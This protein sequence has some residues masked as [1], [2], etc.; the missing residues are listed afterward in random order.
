MI[1]R[2]LAFILPIVLCVLP[3]AP[4]RADEDR[5]GRFGSP[6]PTPVDRFGLSVAFAGD[7][8]LAGSHLD[9][10]AAID[11][12]AVTVFGLDAGAWIAEHTLFDPDPGPTDAFGFSLDVDGSRVLIGIEADRGARGG[13]ALFERTDTGWVATDTLLPRDAEPE[14]GA[15]FDV[16]LDG[17]IA[18]LGSLR[19]DPAGGVWLFEDHGEGFVESL[20]LSPPASS[21]PERFGLSMDLDGER[22][23]VGAPESAE[24]GAVYLFERQAADRWRQVARIP[25]PS[26]GAR[27]GFAV[28]LDGDRLLVGAPD[29]DRHSTDGGAVYQIDRGNGAWSNITP[30]GPEGAFG[31]HGLGGSALA[32]DDPLLVV[33]A[34]GARDSANA[35]GAVLVFGR[36]GDQFRWLRT[37]VAAAAEGSRLGTS[38]AITGG[39]V[40]AGAPF[41]A[42]QG[43]HEAGFVVVTDLAELIGTCVPGVGTICLRDERFEVQVDWTTTDGSTGHGVPVEGT[44]SVDSGLFWFFEVNNWELLVK[45]LDGCS[46][47]DHFWV[48][49]AATT[50]L[51]LL[52]RVTD[53]VTGITRE[54]AKTPGSPAPA[55]TDTSA[56]ATCSN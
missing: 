18:A 17:S 8:L 19:D 10:R 1:D 31:A 54:Y 53:T 7:Q 24:G 21:T 32:F 16:S 38:V 48:F 14:D 9:D 41:G 2:R 30:I 27:F 47:N 5:S 33:G 12:G 3:P 56:F 42:H 40:A 11:G 20:L 13:A 49:S 23:A 34:P 37:I 4:L 45:I 28:L 26:P 51:G 46:T 44:R 39:L 36:R 29:D 43:V 22:L 55:L 52:V 25:S 6:V 50:D 15:G 35:T